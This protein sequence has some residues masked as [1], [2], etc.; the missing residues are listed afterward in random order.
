MKPDQFAQVSGECAVA[1]APYIPGHAHQRGRWGVVEG[2]ALSAQG[3]TGL[4]PGVV[5]G[6]ILAISAA[7]ATGPSS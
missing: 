7:V 1:P 3:R 4:D 2:Q 5:V 6:T